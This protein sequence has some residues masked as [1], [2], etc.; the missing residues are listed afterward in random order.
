MK[1]DIYIYIY[2]NFTNLI[3]KPADLLSVASP[4]K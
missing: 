3:D 1:N 2:N 4:S